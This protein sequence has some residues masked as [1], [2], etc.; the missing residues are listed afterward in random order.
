VPTKWPSAVGWRP[1][2]PFVVTAKG[3]KTGLPLLKGRT[4]RRRN[5]RRRR[6]RRSNLD[7]H[8]LRSSQRL[9]PLRPQLRDRL[10]SPDRRRRARDL[11][12]SRLFSKSPRGRLVELLASA[13]NQQFQLGHHRVYLDGGVGD[14]ANSP[15]GIAFQREHPQIRLQ[16]LTGNLMLNRWYYHSDSVVNTFDKCTHDW[17]RDFL[18]HG[19]VWTGVC[20]NH[21]HRSQ[22]LAVKPLKSSDWPSDP[23][24][25]SWPSFP[26]IVEWMEMLRKGI[27]PFARKE[28][29]TPVGDAGY[30][31]V[32]RRELSENA[33]LATLIV[34]NVV[35]GIRS[36]TELP[37]KYWK[38]FRYRQNFLILTCR[39]ALPIG[40]VR[41]LLGQ[42][43]V[44]PFSLWLRRA[45]TLKSYLRKVPILLVSRARD[46]AA[47]TSASPVV[48]R[49][50]S[51]TP[52]SYSDSSSELLSDYASDD[53][54]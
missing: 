10:E 44:K 33:R 43:C 19:T 15:G 11:L 20:D 9:L 18:N 48:P 53:L 31:C 28:L 12:P 34:S 40:L 1:S 35:V 50:G 25:P 32:S 47:R 22:R 13:S 30:T 36:S 26:S 24:G 14:W 27:D 54:D 4:P 49:H 3:A 16:S 17:F 5:P 29:D 42:W 51:R 52:T 23:L 8:L 38:Y 37:T 41:F 2:L 39:Y 46:W 7:F 21:I 6:R 45:C